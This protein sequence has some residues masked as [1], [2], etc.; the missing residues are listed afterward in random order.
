MFTVLMFFPLLNE[1]DK[2]TIPRARV[3]YLLKPEGSCLHSTSNLACVTL[4]SKIFQDTL[5]PFVI[6]EDPWH[7]MI[8]Y[9]GSYD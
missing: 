1:I 9:G 2:S 6:N 4:T 7:R 5:G 3:E 8:D